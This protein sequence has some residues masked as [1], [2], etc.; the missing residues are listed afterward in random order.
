MAGRRG[1]VR[2]LG[3]IRLS[4]F[5]IGLSGA[6]QREG[7]GVGVGPIAGGRVCGLVAVCGRCVDVDYER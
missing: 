5:I 6:V 2:L 7:L 3:F 4:V 1:T